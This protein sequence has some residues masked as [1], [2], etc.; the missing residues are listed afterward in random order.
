MAE[1]QEMTSAPKDGSQILLYFPGEAEEV[2]MA[3]WSERQLIEA[4]NVVREEIGW[5]MQDRAEVRPE[6]D[7]TMWCAITEPPPAAERRAEP[8]NGS[9]PAS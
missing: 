8:A 6:E 4:G 7:P 1:W 3:V 9:G 5:R 2:R